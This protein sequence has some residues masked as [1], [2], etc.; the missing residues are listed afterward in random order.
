MKPLILL[1]KFDMN[2]LHPDLSIKKDWILL[3][4]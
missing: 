2:K 1:L 3:N 4:T